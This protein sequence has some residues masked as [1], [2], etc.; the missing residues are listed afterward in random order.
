[1]LDVFTYKFR[2]LDLHPCIYGLNAS[3]L[4][5]TT[6]L[7][8]I[9]KDESEITLLMALADGDPDFSLNSELNPLYFY[10]LFRKLN[11]DMLSVFSYAARYSTFNPVEHLWTPLSNHLS[12]VVFS[13]RLKGESKA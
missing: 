8:N 9:F 2:I 7:Y 1:M 6:D 4:S 5:H 10:R 3:I 13:A 11:L 12:G